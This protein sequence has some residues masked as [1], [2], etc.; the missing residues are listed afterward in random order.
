MNAIVY[1]VYRSG[2]EWHDPI[3]GYYNRRA[4]KNRALELNLGKNNSDTFESLSEYVVVHLKMVD[5]K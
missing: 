2:P 3:E 5:A 1:V 4:A